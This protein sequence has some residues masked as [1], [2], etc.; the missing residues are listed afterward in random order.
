MLNKKDINTGTVKNNIIFNLKLH[1]NNK[2]LFIYK[3]N[4]SF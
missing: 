4:I 2:K 1:H 3:Q